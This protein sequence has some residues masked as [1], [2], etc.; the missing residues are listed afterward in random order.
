MIVQGN[1][2]TLSEYIDLMMVTTEDNPAP[3]PCKLQ[4]DRDYP[5]LLSDVTPRFMYAL[6]DRIT[7]KLLPDSFLGGTDTLD[8]FFGSP[9]GQLPYIHYD[10]M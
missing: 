9:G 10:Y 7:S 8:I 3:Y 5:E 1:N 2:Y 6:P 4:I